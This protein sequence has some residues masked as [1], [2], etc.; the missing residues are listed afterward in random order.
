[1]WFPVDFHPRPSVLNDVDVR[2]V[3]VLVLLHEVVGEDGAEELGRI[4]R[5]LLGHNVGCLFH[6]VGSHD[7]AVVGLGVGG[8][9]FAFEENA[10]G[11]FVDCVSF[12]CFVAVDFVKANVVF[13]VAG[14]RDGGHGGG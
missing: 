10:D 11:H 6:A 7:D 9:N 1:M 14:C 12:G 5:V 2:D 8:F 13:A 4:D 3:D